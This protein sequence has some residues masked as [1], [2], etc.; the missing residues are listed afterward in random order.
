MD[1][2]LRIALRGLAAQGP[3]HLSQFIKEAIPMMTQT[4]LNTLRRELDKHADHKIVVLRRDGLGITHPV[5][6]K[7]SEC[8]IEELEWAVNHGRASGRR[9]RAGIRREIHRRKSAQHA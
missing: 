6:K 8:S 4:E 3:G 9:K 7:M 5:T 2:D 1:R